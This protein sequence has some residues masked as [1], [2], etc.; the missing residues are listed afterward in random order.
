MTTTAAASS[1]TPSCST[2]AAAAGCGGG[3]RAAGSARSGERK[4]KRRRRRR[5]RRRGASTAAAAATTPGPLAGSSRPWSR[6]RPSTE[7]ACCCSGAGTGRGGCS[8]TP[9]G[10]SRRLRRR[11]RRWQQA[12]LLPL[13]T[14]KTAPFRGARRRRRPL[15]WRRWLSAGLEAAAA[16]ASG[17][18]GTRWGGRR[19]AAAGPGR[20]SR[21]RGRTA[22]EAPF[23]RRPPPPRLPRSL[24]LLPLFL[25]LH[26]L[27]LRTRSRRR[28]WRPCAPG[29]AAVRATEEEGTAGALRRR[30]P[31]Q[32]PLLLLLLVLPR[33]SAT[34]RAP[35]P[36]S[37]SRS[38]DSVRRRPASSQWWT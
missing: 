23:S 9:G 31:P 28:R 32:L 8:P 13:A 2:A 37:R 7:G 33:G 34:E 20:P 38:R 18:V 10:R 22:T 6:C 5:R 30:L 24:F 29:S 35:R 26:R 1:P 19:A 3:G 11:R 15:R 21:P 4:T 27:L 25:C 36:S 16:S 17:G 14:L 12:L